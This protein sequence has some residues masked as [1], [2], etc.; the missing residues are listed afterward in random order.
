MQYIKRNDDEYEH[1]RRWCKGDINAL[2]FLRAVGLVAQI[3]DDLVDEELSPPERGDLVTKLLHISM[4][5]IPSNPFYCTHQK[6]FM[7]LF[8][9]SIAQ[10]SASNRWSLSN[11]LNDLVFAFVYRDLYEQIIYQTALLIGGYKWANA[12]MDEIQ[13]YYHSSNPLAEWIKEVKGG[14]R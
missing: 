12:V 13:S 6:W 5:S 8:S 4:V 10:W 11:N 2:E 14:S 7:P 1:L 3:A 9:T